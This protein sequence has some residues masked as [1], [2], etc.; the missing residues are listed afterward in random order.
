MDT[1]SFI[2]GV[3]VGVAI[4]GIAFALTVLLF[5]RIFQGK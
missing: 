2:L 5:P 4:A 1:A 3:I